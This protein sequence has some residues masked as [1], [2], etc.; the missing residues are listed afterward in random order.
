METPTMNERARQELCR[1]LRNEAMA[2]IALLDFIEAVFPPPADAKTPPVTQPKIVHPS[3]NN[4]WFD[5]AA[6]DDVRM[7]RHFRNDARGVWRQGRPA[8]G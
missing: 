3:I 8:W 1:A 6:G 4:D 2:V 7:L 5:K